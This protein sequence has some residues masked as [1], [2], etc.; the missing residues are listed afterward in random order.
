VT[1]KRT[2]FDTSDH[3]SSTIAVLAWGFTTSIISGDDLAPIADI[4]EHVYSELERRSGKGQLSPALATQAYLETQNIFVQGSALCELKSGLDETIESMTI[5]LEGL[6]GSGPHREHQ[7]PRRAAHSVAGAGKKRSCLLLPS[8]TAKRTCQSVCFA[9]DFSS[10]SSDDDDYTPAA[11]R[12]TKPKSRTT[13]HPTPPPSPSKPSP[14]DHLRLWFLQNLSNPYPTPYEK[15]SLATAAGCPRS[16]VDSDLTNWRRRS[17]WTDIKD[18]WAGGDKAKMKRLIEDVEGG[19]ERR[20]EV[21]EEVERM[22]GYLE[23]RDQE[24]V[25]DWVHEVSLLS[26]AEMRRY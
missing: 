23:R 18:R 26:S 21:V 16:K 13:L 17:G 4:W 11:S 7:L 3:L 6:L 12:L 14:T 1:S 2:M 20:E 5:D 9:S 8:R 15:E 10:D 22:R 19:L 25:G 24:R